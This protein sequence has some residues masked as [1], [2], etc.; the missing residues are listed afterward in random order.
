MSHPDKSEAI[1]NRLIDIIAFLNVEKTLH[2]NLYNLELP[3]AVD[4]SN[5]NRD[6]ERAIKKVYKVI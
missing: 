3:I 2:G 5:A 6:T 4:M 1:K